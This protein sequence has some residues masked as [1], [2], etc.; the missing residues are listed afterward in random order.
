MYQ[1]T[2]PLSSCKLCKRTLRVDHQRALCIYFAESSMQQFLIASLQPLFLIQG[3]PSIPAI[4][5]ISISSAASA[6]QLMS[7]SRKSLTNVSHSREAERPVST[8]S[9]NTRYNLSDEFPFCAPPQMLW[10]ARSM[11]MKES[12]SSTHHLEMDLKKQSQLQ[13]Q[14]T[15]KQN[16]P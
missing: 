14:V 13:P 15:L 9:K 5:L 2:R 7:S 10:I 8:P 16:R 4:N 6:F 1:S 3:L 11:D 12:L